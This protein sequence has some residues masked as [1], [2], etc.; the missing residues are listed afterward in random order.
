[1][2]VH[3]FCDGDAHVIAL[4]G[5]LDLFSADGVE[6]ELRRVELT[7]VRVIVIDLRELTFIDSTGI[8]LV[9]LANRRSALGGG[10]LLVL[11]APPTV[12]H[13]FELCGLGGSIAFADE[14]QQAP[15][16]LVG[17]AGIGA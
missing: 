8:R 2:R 6:S 4:A 15:S 3:S 13:T 1:L 12:H 7:S 16:L 10:R 9:V 17:E 5:E 11:R 14:L